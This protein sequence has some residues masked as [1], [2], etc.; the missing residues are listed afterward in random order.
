MDIQ[1]YMSIRM[2]KRGVSIFLI[3]AI[4]IPFFRPSVS[5]ASITSDA[6]DIGKCTAA[7]LVGSIVSYGVGLAIAAA[8]GEVPVKDSQNISKEYIMD[9][10]ARCIAR[11]YLEGSVGAILDVVRTEGRDGGTAYIQ[12][13]RNFQTNAQYRGE[14]IFRAVLAN[15]KVCSFLEKDIKSVFR[16]PSTTRI[17]TAGQNSRIGDVDP[18]E[19]RAKCTLPS[20]F[21]PAKYQ[22]DFTNNGGW[23]AY[24]QLLQPQNNFYGLY[25]TSQNELEKNRALELSNDLNEQDGGYTSVRGSSASASCQIPGYNGRCLFYNNIKSPAKFIGD[26]AA[27]TVHAE[28]GWLTSADELNEVVS[29]VITQFLLRRIE[30]L[31]AP[32]EEEPIYGADPRP[33]ESAILYPPT[34][35]PTPT[36]TFDPFPTPSGGPGPGEGEDCAV[37]VAGGSGPFTDDI[38]ASGDQLHDERPD[39]LS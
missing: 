8:L 24:S 12:N 34:P 15:T 17:S 28:L 31:G 32:E 13:W 1:K 4:C 6:V 2:L 26:A 19:L 20:N 30:N 39:I 9:T 23:V 21:D 37:E 25:L 36:I 18:Y 3:L 38:I 33:N 22:Q 14:N 5:S 27:A 29:T 16:V 7:G 10:A 11:Q 35:V